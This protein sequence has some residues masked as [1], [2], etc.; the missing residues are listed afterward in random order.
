M[1]RFWVIDDVYNKIDNNFYLDTYDCDDI[2]IGG[3]NTGYIKDL[4]KRAV[5]NYHYLF[6]EEAK[7]E[8]ALA[9]SNIGAHEVANRIAEEECSNDEIIDNMFGKYTGPVLIFKDGKGYFTNCQSYNDNKYEDF[10]F[11]FNLDEVRCSRE[12]FIKELNINQLINE[13]KNYYLTHTWEEFE[14]RYPYDYTL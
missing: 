9:Y 12:E 11:G 5:C 8:Q 14:D 13:I 1:V 7:A 2:N 10:S 6:S 4:L 3:F